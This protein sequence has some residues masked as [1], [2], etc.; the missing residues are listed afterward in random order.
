M[1][2][3]TGPVHGVWGERDRVWGVPWFFLAGSGKASDDLRA[4]RR[5]SSDS[6]LLLACRHIHSA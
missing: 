1:P 5:Q 2:V 4:I 3:E 6:T